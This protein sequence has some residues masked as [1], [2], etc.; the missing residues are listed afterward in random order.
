MF[1]FGK[2]DGLF[3]VCVELWDYPKQ[4]CLPDR[5]VV[6]NFERCAIYIYILRG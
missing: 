1:L 3:I 4:W 5:S 2:Q 6:D